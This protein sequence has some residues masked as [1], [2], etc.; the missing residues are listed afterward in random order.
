MLIVLK[1]LVKI[2]QKSTIVNINYL[3]I[4]KSTSADSVKSSNI[5]IT[6]QKSNVTRVYCNEINN[7][8]AHSKISYEL[9]TLLKIKK[10]SNINIIIKKKLNPQA[11]DI[12]YE[13]NALNKLKKVTNASKS[14]I[15][16][17]NKNITQIIKDNKVHTQNEINN[18]FTYDN[19]KKAH[20]KSVIPVNKVHIE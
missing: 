10:V 17:L 11:I 5:K 15:A 3:D 16:F 4:P 1:A 18:T 8:S 7:K 20:V 13:L 12:K 14:V 2:K 19:I 9:S 6:K